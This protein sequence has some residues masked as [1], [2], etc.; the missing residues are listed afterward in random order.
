MQKR[1]A[2]LEMGPQHSLQKEGL[3]LQAR[4][5]PSPFV[6]PNSKTSREVTTKFV[7]RYRGFWE[8]NTGTLPLP[9]LSEL[10]F[11]LLK[12][13]SNLLG[14]KRPKFPG[15]SRAKIPVYPQQA[16]DQVQGWAGSSQP[17]TKQ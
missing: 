9:M 14:V 10:G 17:S 6:S 16:E 4:L 7:R 3:I 2:G 1:R 8:E 12:E 13:G 15:G 5:D 11:H